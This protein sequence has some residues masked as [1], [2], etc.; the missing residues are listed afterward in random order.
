MLH[1][2]RFLMRH[3]KSNVCFQFSKSKSKVKVPSC[4]NGKVA[5]CAI[6]EHFPDAGDTLW[7]RLFRA[8]TATPVILAKNSNK[9]PNFNL[10]FAV[11]EAQGKLVFV[12]SA[13]MPF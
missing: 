6:N 11:Y 9:Y 4:D 1:V 5:F 10:S 13:V 3:R 7:L 8:P 12:C 2:S